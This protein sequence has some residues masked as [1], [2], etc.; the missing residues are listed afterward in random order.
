VTSF[1]SDVI[2][3]HQTKAIQRWADR[4]WAGAERQDD[5]NEKKKEKGSGPF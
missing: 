2:Q 4:K 5:E 1:H 3:R